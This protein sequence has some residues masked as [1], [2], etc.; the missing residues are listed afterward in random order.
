MT[1][2]VN[3]HDAHRADYIAAGWTV[4]DIER[5][6]TQEQLDEAI[7]LL[8]D[9]LDLFSGTHE[10][11]DEVTSPEWVWRWRTLYLLNDIEAQQ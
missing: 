5:P 7:K 4:T 2:N 3:T 6:T 11:C 1:R 8:S 10:L 9:A